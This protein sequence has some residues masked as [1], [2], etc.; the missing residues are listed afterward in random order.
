M[1]I[2]YRGVIP[3][4]PLTK[5]NNLYLSLL[6]S[7]EGFPYGPSINAFTSYL[8]NAKLYKEFVQSPNTLLFV[9][10]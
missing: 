3:M 7:V 5:I 6:I 1:A 2:D 8:F 10:I 4:P 9:K